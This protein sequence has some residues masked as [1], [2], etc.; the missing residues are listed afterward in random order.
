MRVLGGITWIGVCTENFEESVAFF[1]NVMG[2]RVVQEGI[3]WVD[4]QYAKYCVFDAGNNVMFELLQPTPA[5]TGRYSGPVV[6][7]TVD[8][9]DAAMSEMQ[10]RAEFITPVIDD[11]AT[12]RW[13]YFRAPDGNIY[14]LQQKR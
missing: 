8:D 7:F 12:W 13:I 3:P 6:S 11:K 10:G 2:L 1:K 14:Q 9:L 5:I 4:L